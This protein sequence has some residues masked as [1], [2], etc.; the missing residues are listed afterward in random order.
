MLGREKQKVPQHNTETLLFA[1]LLIDHHVTGVRLR[2]LKTLYFLNLEPFVFEGS[3]R[4]ADGGRTHNIR[5]HS[6][7]LCH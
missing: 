3:R 6:A 4:V 1:A 7:T 2:T 5:I